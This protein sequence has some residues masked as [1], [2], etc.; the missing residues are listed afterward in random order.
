MSSCFLTDCLTLLKPCCKMTQVS[1]AAFKSEAEFRADWGS[2]LV[3]R[4]LPC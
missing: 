2:M 1:A 3:G 4:D